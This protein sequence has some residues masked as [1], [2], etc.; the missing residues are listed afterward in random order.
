MKDINIKVL[1]LGGLFFTQ[2]S[3]TFAESTKVF[4]DAFIYKISD[5][6]YSIKDLQKVNK[7]FKTLKCYYSQS[8][9][10]K[11]FDDLIV[12]G[13]SKNLFNVKDYT[14]T[15]YSKKQIEYF[16][17]SLKL[18]KL[19]YYSD[20]H[21]TPVKKEVVKAF[22]LA[23]KQLSCDKSVFEGTSEFRSDFNDLMR[24]EI[25]LRSRYLP[26]EKSGKKTKSDINQAVLGIKTLLNSIDKQVSEETFW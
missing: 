7:N 10:L 12:M 3:N 13:K 21:K 20:S 19:K 9:L 26:E 16:E 11:V 18:F 17:K 15:P 4:S 5:Q 22:Y 24:M 1:L 6:V 25:F 14:K 23:S 8:L 2:I